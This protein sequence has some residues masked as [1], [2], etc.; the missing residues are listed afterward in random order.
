MDRDPQAPC[1]TVLTD[2][3]PA[4]GKINHTIQPKMTNGMATTGQLGRLDIQQ[5]RLA[6]EKN[7][8]TKDDLEEMTIAT[9]KHDTDHTA[10]RL[11]SN[12]YTRSKSQGDPLSETGMTRNT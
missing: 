12:Q 3:H 10:Q 11:I 9:V 1:Q 2:H 4:K 7:T 8:G 5:I 6:I